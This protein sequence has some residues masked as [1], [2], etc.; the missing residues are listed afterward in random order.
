MKTIS[1][2]SMAIWIKNLI[3]GLFMTMAMFIVIPSLASAAGST[4]GILV[5]A[6]ADLESSNCD[7][8]GDV[9]GNSGWGKSSLTVWKHKAEHRAM[10]MAKELNATHVYWEG[11]STGGYGSSPQA[12]GKAYRCDGLG[13]SNEIASSDKDAS[14]SKATQLN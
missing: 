13:K 7:Y 12:Y 14:S 10:K 1:V 8:V 3:S 11:N 4:H 2:N 6:T 9:W 5:L